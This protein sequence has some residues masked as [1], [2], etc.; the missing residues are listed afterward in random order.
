MAIKRH[1]GFE[2]KRVA[3]AEA[4]RL[5][6]AA[7]QLVP[8]L[9]ALRLADHDLDAV[10]TRVAGATE[11]RRLTLVARRRRKVIAELACIR[12]GKS[13]H[14]RDCLGSLNRD[15]AR[16]ER[17]IHRLDIETALRFR[18][19]SDDLLTIAG[20]DDHGPAVR[21]AIDENVVADAAL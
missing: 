11:Y 1:A 8:E 15:H 6:A 12:L 5:A 4:T 21:P 3:R 7:H 18:E 10:F 9:F 14:H 20:V 2:P 13:G 17:L 19:P 16:V